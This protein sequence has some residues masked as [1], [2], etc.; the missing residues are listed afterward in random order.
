[1]SAAVPDAEDRER[2]KV[3]LKRRTQGIESTGA[4]TANLQRLPKVRAKNSSTGARRRRS[5]CRM[6]LAARHGEE[7]AVE[8]TDSASSTAGLRRGSGCSRL[9]MRLTECAARM[10]DESAAVAPQKTCPRRSRLLSRLPMKL[11]LWRPS[12]RLTRH[13]HDIAIVAIGRNKGLRTCQHGA[14]SRWWMRVTRG[15]SSTLQTNACTLGQ[16]RVTVRYTKEKRELASLW[17]RRKQVRIAFQKARGVT[18]KVKQM[19]AR[20]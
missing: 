7:I 8:Q 13:E 6:L 18:A 10:Q 19:A 1:M 5:L 11:P 2:I 14:M 3:T 9:W 15:C 16:T 17:A 20:P 4:S 12:Y